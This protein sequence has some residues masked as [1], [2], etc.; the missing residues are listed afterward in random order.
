LGL[1]VDIL[2]PNQKDLA[3]YKIVLTPGLMHINK[4]LKAALESFEGTVI[5][6]PRTGSKTLDMSIPNELPPQVPGIVGKVA[7][8]E[9]LRPNALIPIINGGTFK[10]WMETLVDCDSVIESCDD[11]RPAVIGQKDRMYIAGWGNQEALKRI[12]KDACIYQNITTIELPD[13]VRVRETF[14]HR[15]WF[16]YSDSETRIGATSLRPSGVLWEKL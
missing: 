15:F 1:S 13:C 12:L 4:D 7:R 3:R 14:S 8:V 16:N 6:G 9:S 11:G 2:S 10:C 5:S